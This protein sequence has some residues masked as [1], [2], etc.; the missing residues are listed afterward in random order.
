VFH[1]ERF[2][3]TNLYVQNCSDFRCK[4]FS[5]LDLWRHLWLDDGRCDALLRDSLSDTLLGSERSHEG[6]CSNLAARNFEAAS[7]N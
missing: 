4:P 2:V 7:S 5:L 1:V 3:C 6:R